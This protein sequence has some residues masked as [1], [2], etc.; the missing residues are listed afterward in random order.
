MQLNTTIAA[1]TTLDEEESS[2]GVKEPG[3]YKVIL[4]DVKESEH[5]EGALDFY[6]KVTVGAYKGSVVRDTLNDPN[7]AKNENASAVSARRL[8]LYAGRLGLWDGKP[9]DAI[10][11]N[12]PDAIGREYVVHVVAD[13]Y[14]KDDQTRTSYKPDFAGVFP[15]DHPKIPAA[16]RTALALPPA[17]AGAADGKAATPAAAVTTGGAGKAKVNYGT[18]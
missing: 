18:L 5:L 17:R 6:F 10:N 7:Y 9:G 8:R 1:P 13:T 14:K 2:G 4:D 15:P 11:V 3:Y 12:W 16:V